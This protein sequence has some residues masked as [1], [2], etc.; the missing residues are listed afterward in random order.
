MNEKP[1]QN[2]VNF[3]LRLALAGVILFAFALVYI[4]REEIITWATELP[5]RFSVRGGGFPLELDG[6]VQPQLYA[7]GSGFAA[8]NDIYVTMYNKDGAK[9]SSERHNCKS[10]R[11][12][13]GGG[14]LVVFDEYATKITMYN[15]NGKVA[16]CQAG[17][18]DEN[19]RRTDSGKAWEISSAAV[20][21]NGNAA[22]IAS[23]DE[24]RNIVVVF[25]KSGEFRYLHIFLDD[26]AADCVPAENG[27][28]VA[29]RG[30]ENGD[31]ACGLQYF[32]YSG[33]EAAT[34][35]VALPK[36]SLV[37]KL[38]RTNNTAAVLCD[39]GA[40]F[41]NAATF[42]QKGAY[43]LGG[44][45]IFAAKQGRDFFTLVTTD[46]VDGSR[47]LITIDYNGDVIGA[48]KT[49]PVSVAIFGEIVYTLEE[50]QVFSRSAEL[51]GEI[52]SGVDDSISAIGSFAVTDNGLV[53]A[54]S[55][56]YIYILE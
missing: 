1:K 21:D 23:S 47:R 20:G 2:R 3:T 26:F 19:G 27:V 36:G 6:G 14:T 13:T 51:D 8:V 7:V 49:N 35:S 15:K 18:Y 39:D 12:L 41:V 55:N 31:F 30:A 56:G 33:E 52:L 48:L 10:P 24:Y 9:L 44:D 54:A 53:V 16:E 38:W 29:T 25:D 46:A 50:G 4:N 43:S 42:E 34:R 45:G 40:L 37:L 32:E 11:V 22:V 28:Y 17:L 5:E